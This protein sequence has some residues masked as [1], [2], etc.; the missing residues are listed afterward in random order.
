MKFAVIGSN[1]VADWFI[2]AGKRCE[3]FELYAILFEDHG[4]R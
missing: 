2:E 4:T 3:G 1:F